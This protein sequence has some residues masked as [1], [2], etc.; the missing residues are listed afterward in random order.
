ML[1]Y[2][3]CNN[4]DRIAQKICDSF[5]EI[6]LG[7]GKHWDCS[8]PERSEKMG[9]HCEIPFGVSSKHFT[10]IT[11]GKVLYTY[12]TFWKVSKIIYIFL[13]NLNLKYF[14]KYF[15]LNPWLLLM[16]NKRLII[17]FKPLYG[18]NLSLICNA[19]FDFIAVMCLS[20][21]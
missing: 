7:G 3:C 9:S 12:I 8:E 20:C 6:W 1:I 4:V 18:F 15:Y 21:W 10:S 13:D 5:L 17:A 14:K 19:F 11:V 16:W 2:I